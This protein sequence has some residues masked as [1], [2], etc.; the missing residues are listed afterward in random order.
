MSQ[1]CDLEEEASADNVFIVNDGVQATMTCIQDEEGNIFLHPVSLE[2]DH[3]VEVSE[4]SADSY[5]VSQVQIVVQEPSSDLA[6]SEKGEL[7][8]NNSP[9]EFTVVPM[10][11]EASVNLA[12]SSLTQSSSEAQDGADFACGETSQLSW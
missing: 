10:Y 6:S 7:Y 11:T 8:S 4:S 1:L 9:E 3:I 12:E 5:E 2:D